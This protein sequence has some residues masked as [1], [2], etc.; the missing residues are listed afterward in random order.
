MKARQAWYPRSG[1]L[2]FFF[3]LASAVAAAQTTQ[4]LISGRLLNSETGRPIPGEKIV[5]AS[6]L[7]DL[8]GGKVSDVSGYNFSGCLRLVSTMS[9]QPLVR[10]GH[11][12]RDAKALA[13]YPQAE[14]NLGGVGELLDYDLASLSGARSLTE[15]APLALY[16]LQVHQ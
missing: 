11:Y 5:N 8:V 1:A 15:T 6:S 2:V 12:V 16:D 4:G 10:Q 14:I 13:Q 9:A 3:L 7:T